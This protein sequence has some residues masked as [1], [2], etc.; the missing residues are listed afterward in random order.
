MQST[1]NSSWHLS[2]VLISISCY[3]Y[4]YNQQL[5]LLLLLLWCIA[6]AESIYSTLQKSAKDSVVFP[7]MLEYFLIFLEAFLSESDSFKIKN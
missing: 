7:L 2:K 6:C 5:L 4:Y 1:Y 3:Y